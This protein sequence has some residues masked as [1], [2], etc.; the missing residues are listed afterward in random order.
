MDE[1]LERAETIVFDIGNVLLRF[2]PD[3]VIGLLP[4]SIRQPLLYVLFGPPHLWDAF[5]LGRESNPDI[6]RRVAQATG[7]PES[8]GWALE[9]LERFPETL[10]P[11]PLYHLLD[12]LQARGKRL[13]GLTN[14]PEPSFTLTC[15]RF[16]LLLGKLTGVVVSS[17]EKVAKPQPEIFRLLIQ[18]YH[19]DPPRTLFIDD[20]AANTEAAAREGFQI[21]H[22]AAPD[23]LG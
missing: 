11:L 23:C 15:Q 22:Y 14:Y 6:A 3:K 16:P 21:W 1:R 7:I 4:D 17:R 10:T 18:R 5:D 12:D 13:Y 8:K 2:S 20:S 9:L 19:L